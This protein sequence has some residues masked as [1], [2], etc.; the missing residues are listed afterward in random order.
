MT[1][2]ERN[3]ILLKAL[4][5]IGAVGL[6]VTAVAIPGIVVALAP[7]LDK[8]KRLRSIHK[9]RLRETMQ[10]ARHCRWIK[11]VHGPDGTH[12]VLT[13]TGKRR[14]QRLLLSKPLHRGRWDKHWRLVL[15]DVPSRKHSVR[16]QLRQHLRRLGMVQYQ[17]SVWLTP[18]PCDE[19][20]A[21]LKALYF[22]APHV[23]V[24]KAT[25]IDGEQEYLDKFNLVR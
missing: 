4:G 2:E 8:D 1:K 15:F 19:E 24:V 23:K 9:S 11:A 21:T 25:Y 7:F 10:Y 14:L 5:I 3:E 13:R 6:V 12:I 20:I 22:I 18:Y 16:D 17:E